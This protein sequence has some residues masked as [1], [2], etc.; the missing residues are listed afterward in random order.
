MSPTPSMIGADIMPSTLGEAIL[1]RQEHFIFRPLGWCYF[2]GLPV[3]ALLLNRVPVEKG[4]Q[5]L[6]ERGQLCA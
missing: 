2:A 4:F 1:V 6:V 5:A 3:S